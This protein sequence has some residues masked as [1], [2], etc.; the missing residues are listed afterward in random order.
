MGTASGD[1]FSID[2]SSFVVEGD[3]G[4]VGIGTTTP[5]EKLDVNG[6]I[7]IADG[8]YYKYGGQNALRLAKGTD[9]YYAN[10]FVGLYAGNSSSTRQ[11]ALGYL[12][13]NSNTGSN[14]T[15]LG[16]Y[17]GQSNSGT[18]QTAIGYSAGLSNTGAYQTALGYWAGSYNDGDYNT[19][20]GRDAFNDWTADTG[21]ALT[22]SSVDYANNQVTITGHGLT[23]NQNFKASTTGTMPTGLSTSENQWKVI[24]ANTLEVITDSFT[25]AGTGTLTLTPKVIYSNSGAFGYNAEPDASNQIMLGNTALTQVKTSGSIYSSGTGDNYFAG[26]VGIGTTSPTAVLHLKAGTATASTAPL[27]FTS[28]TLLTTPEAG[29]VEFLTDAYYGTITTGAS[30]KDRKSTRLN[31]SHT[32]ISRMPSSA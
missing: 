1:D 19:A 32:D 29:A 31:S 28:G 24:D 6:N 4:N 12:A 18:N 7:N 5:S 16:F 15:A 22:V 27:K 3:T 23:S 10:T 14:Q 25:D 26:N 13:G 11:T 17:A 2:T 8:Q 9:A 30:R 20:I 21:N